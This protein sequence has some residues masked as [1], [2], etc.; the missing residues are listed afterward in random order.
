L[1]TATLPIYEAIRDDPGLPPQ[2]LPAGWPQPELR[3]ALTEALVRLTPGVRSYIEQLRSQLTPKP[4][5]RR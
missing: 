2:L 4:K 3:A 1:A 5:S